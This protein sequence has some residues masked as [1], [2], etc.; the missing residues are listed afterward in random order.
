MSG[1]SSE[2]GPVDVRLRLSALWIAMLFIFAYVDIFSLY[3]PNVRA[4]LA[5]DKPG[6]FDVNRAFLFGTTLYIVVPSLMVYLSLVMA[7]RLGRIVNMTAAAVSA[8][9][10]AG[11]AVGEQ[12]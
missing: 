11:G 2:V 4:D 12:S 5:N 6:V 10:I 8:M 1:T 7:R 9:T 3:W